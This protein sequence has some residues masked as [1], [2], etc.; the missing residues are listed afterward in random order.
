M[1]GDIQRLSEQVDP[2]ASATELTAALARRVISSRELLEEYLTRV[3]R[4]NPALNAV[5]TVDAE[6]A[7]AAAVYARL[8]DDLRGRTDRRGIRAGLAGRKPRCCRTPHPGR[9]VAV[10][11]RGGVPIAARASRRRAARRRPPAG[12]LGPK[13]YAASARPSIRGGAALAV[14]GRLGGLLPRLRHAP[15]PGDPDSRHPSRPE[16]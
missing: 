8:I 5:V 13:R 4:Y 16:R 14:E 3:E 12:A 11:V 9:R 10:A 7:L 6:R 15:L 2:F 1:P